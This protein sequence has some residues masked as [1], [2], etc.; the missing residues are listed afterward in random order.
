MFLNDLFVVKV[1]QQIYAPRPI[2]TQS[3]EPSPRGVEEGG[4]KL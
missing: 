4:H 1:V 3:A 2:K